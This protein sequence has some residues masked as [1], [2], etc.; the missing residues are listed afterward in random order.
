VYVVRFVE[1]NRRKESSPWSIRQSLVY[2]QSGLSSKCPRWLFIAPSHAIRTQ[3]SQYAEVPKNDSESNSFVL[4]LLIVNIVVATWRRYLIYLA[5][6]VQ[7][8]ADRAILAEIEGERTQFAQ[9]EE[10]QRLKQLEDLITDLTGALDSLQDVCHTLSKRHSMYQA[11][12]QS[13]NRPSNHSNDLVPDLVS[14]GLQEKMADLKHYIL[15]ADSLRTKVKSASD[16]IANVLDLGNG[17]ALKDLAMESRAENALMHAMTEKA[18]RDAAAVKVLTVI[19]LVY[20]PATVVL[21]SS[22][23]C[24]I[25]CFGTVCEQ[26]RRTFSRLPSSVPQCPKMALPE[27]R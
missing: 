12:L 17:N 22:F 4:H 10:G 20:L 8:Q 19:T 25:L 1:L 18:T 3:I 26:T 5:E 11:Y 27:L 9:L 23:P 13:T 14:E 24:S 21:V 16:L 2:Y 15:Q 7:K 6:E